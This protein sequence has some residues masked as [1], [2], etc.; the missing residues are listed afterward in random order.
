MPRLLFLRS[1]AYG[2]FHSFLVIP[3]TIHTFTTDSLRVYVR[4]SL[5]VTFDFAILPRCLLIATA[6]SLP[7]AFLFVHRSTRLFLVGPGD[8]RPFRWMLLRC[9]CSRA[10]PLRS[11]PTLHALRYLT[12]LFTACSS[13][14]TTL[15]RLHTLHTHRYL[16]PHR[17]TLP[18]YQFVD[19][20]SRLFPRLHARLHSHCLHVAVVFIHRLFI[21]TSYHHT[22]LCLPVISTHHTGPS[23]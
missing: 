9:R 8:L 5:F 19:S 22:R 12:T 23:R 14:L 7:V 21:R 3:H 10:F 4:C 2:R 17:Y 11:L 20:R 15:L 13:Y 16:P 6:F 1:I 18:I